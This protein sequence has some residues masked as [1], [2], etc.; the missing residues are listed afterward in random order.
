MNK[1]KRWL[2]LLFFCVILAGCSTTQKEEQAK[3]RKKENEL[4]KVEEEIN[5]IE[6]RINEIDEEMATE[7]VCT[8]VQRCMELQKEKDTI[9]Q[10]LEELYEK[11]EELA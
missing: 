3:Q 6:E 4:K 7:E 1:R 10:R 2:C 5:S 11:W 8:D 9:S